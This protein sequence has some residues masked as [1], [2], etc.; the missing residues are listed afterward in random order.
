M[1]EVTR[2]IAAA[3]GRTALAPGKRVEPSIADKGIRRPVGPAEESGRG[4]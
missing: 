2:T 4:R 1:A 3:G